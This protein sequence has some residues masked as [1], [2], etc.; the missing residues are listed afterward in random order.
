MTLFNEPPPDNIIEFKR[1]DPSD[2]TTD[3]D[4]ALA[5][6][7]RAECRHRSRLID[8]EQRE[9]HCRDCGQKLDPVW[10]L[11]NLAEYHDALDRKLVEI[12]AHDQRMKERQARAI[13]ARQRRIR[14][15]GLPVSGC[16]CSGTGWMTVSEAG[17]PPAVKR[18]T[19]RTTG[20]PRLL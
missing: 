18:C 9:V 12:R 2:A 16:A 15:S 10:C 3:V 19:C 13:T 6:A 8:A 5:R 4:G 17:K 14:V 11:L 1:R 20:A 7:P